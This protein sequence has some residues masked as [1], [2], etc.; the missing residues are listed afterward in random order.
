MRSMPAESVDAVVC[1]PPYELGFMGK[2]WDSSG[3]AFDPATWR[4]AL[5]VLK[6]GGYLLAFGGTRTYHRMTTAIE[7]AGADVR[8]CIGWQYGNGFPKSLDVSKAID[9]AAGAERKVLSSKPAYGIGGYGTAFRGHAEGAM[10]T[11]SLPATDEAA[12]WQGWGTALK[13]AWEPVVVARKP[14][15]GT[16]AAN[17]LRYGTGAMNIDG[18]RVGEELRYNPAAGNKAGT[19][20]LNM[21]VYGMPQDA[22]GRH[23]VGRW[24]ANVIL[25]HAPE[26]RQIG[27]QVDTFGGGAKAT[28]GFVEGYESG[29]GFVG[30]TVQTAVWECVEGCPCAAMGAQSGGDGASRFF[31]QLPVET[32]DL[33]PFLY[34]SKAGRKEREAGCD[35]LPVRSGAAVVEREEGSA[36][37]QSPRAGAGRTAD[38]VRNHHPTVKPVSVMRWLCRLVTRPGGTVLDPFMGSGT[39]GIAALAEG[40]DFIGCEREPEYMAIAQARIMHSIG[41]S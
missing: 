14:M 9:K 40:F 10:A 30:Q 33:T 18:C 31:T 24:P 3:V 28:S 19:S 23:T 38:A 11:T 15:V 21:S 34:T 4:E 1:D 8:D 37:T 12:K 36:G 41:K 20:S 16:V 27:P 26:C 13:P 5:R 7:D 39:T 35:A 29:D 25:S 17:L 6:P 32:D 22:E 2:S